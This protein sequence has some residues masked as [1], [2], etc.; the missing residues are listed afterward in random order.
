MVY[1]LG[2]VDYF[3]CKRVVALAPGLTSYQDAEFLRRVATQFPFQIQAIQSYGGSEFLKGFGTAVA[4]LRLIPYFNRP[5]YPQG[6]GRI[7]RSFR[8]YH[9]WLNTA[10]TGKEVLPD[11]P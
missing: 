6:N 2:A 4:E 9:H 8:L 1:Q 11:I 7:E 5:N 10:A 3:T